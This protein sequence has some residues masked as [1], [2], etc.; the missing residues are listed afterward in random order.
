MKFYELD[1]PFTFGKYRG[2]NLENIFVNDPSYVDWCI[3]KLDHFIVEEDI[4]DELVELNPNYS[5]SQ[6]SM[7]KLSASWKKKEGNKSVLWEIPRHY[8]HQNFHDD[9]DWKRES[10]DAMTDGQYGSYDDFMENGGDW[11]RMMDG[12]GY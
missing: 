8:H 3:K 9:T 12:M 1:T 7:N 2:Q 10:F 4:Y 6:E 11:D 5:F